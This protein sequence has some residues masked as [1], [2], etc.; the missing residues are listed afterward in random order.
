MPAKLKS[1]IGLSDDEL[2][3]YV[4]QNEGIYDEYFDVDYVNSIGRNIIEFVDKN[5]FR[6]RYIGFED[7]P[8]R[9][10]PDSPLIFSSNHS[11]MAF[12]WDAMIFTAGL[13]RLS[14]YAKENTVRPLTAPMLSQSTLM[15][16]YLIPYFWKRAGGIDATY[17]NFETLMY[18]NKSHV[19]VYPEGV[20]GIGKGFNRRYQ[21]QRCATSFIRMSLKYKTDIIPI[22]T[23]NGEYINP[24]SY[25]SRLV[26][27]LSQKVGIP[28]IP[29][30]PMT[31]LIPFFPWLFYFAFPAN[32]IYVMGRRIK[33]Y[34]LIDK[35]YSEITDDEIRQVR[36]F[37]QQQ[38]QEDLNDAVAKYGKHPYKLG[39]L[40]QNN[41]K[42]LGNIPFFN[43]PGWPLLFAEH[44]RLYKKHKGKPFTMK[45]DLLSIIKVVLKNPMSIFFFIPLVGWIPIIIKGYAKQRKKSPKQPS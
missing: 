8:T 20:P 36:D 3:E 19:L 38:M 43:S 45:M 1:T 40:I 24:Y 4:K 29:V 34:E 15:N 27:A 37:V 18:F 6:A 5:Y 44:E 16:P 2:L 25:R 28:F 35:P 22:S 7:F 14:E 39:E 42:N 26:N 33:P 10:N 23:V 21:L 41:F 12:P 11:G 30:S 9:N 17:L 13:F 32:L 31:L